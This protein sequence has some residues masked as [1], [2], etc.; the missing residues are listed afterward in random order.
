MQEK[1]S[2]AAGGRGSDEMQLTSETLNILRRDSQ[3]IKE[4]LNLW[5]LQRAC[6]CVFSCGGFLL[7]VREWTKGFHGL[8][9][10]IPSSV[11]MLGWS[12]MSIAS[13]MM[14]SMYVTLVE[15]ISTAVTLPPLFV[16]DAASSF[17]NL[18]F[19]DYPEREEASFPE[20][21]VVNCHGIISQKTVIFK[22][23]CSIWLH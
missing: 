4:S 20:T 21:L 8:L 11:F 13:L 15:R 19:F 3:Q 22:L 14:R 12:L 16:H 1:W 23:R 17:S 7:S 18:F 2:G 6:C 10:T 5:A 9:E